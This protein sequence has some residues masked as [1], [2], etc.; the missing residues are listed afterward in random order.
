MFISIIF[1]FL[2]SCIQTRYRTAEDTL[3]L[4]NCADKQILDSIKY[5][6][7]LPDDYF[8][9]PNGDSICE[10]IIKQGNKIVPCLI[11][12]IKDTTSTNLRIAASY[13]YVVGDIAVMLLPHVLEQELEFNIRELIF[14]EFNKE[15]KGDYNDFFELIYYKIFFSNIPKENYKNRVRFYNRVRTWYEKQK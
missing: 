1:P 3:I 15:L 8:F 5:I 2:I 11:E 4:Q 12:K 6:Y 13:N 9:Y 7:G 14:D 10:K